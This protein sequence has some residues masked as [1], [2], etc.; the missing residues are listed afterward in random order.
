ACHGAAE[1]ERDVQK[2]SPAVLRNVV[3]RKPYAE[4]AADKIGPSSLSVTA[5]A[6]RLSFR[7]CPLQPFS[8][9][10][11]HFVFNFVI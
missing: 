4:T 10:Q 8:H 3:D 11:T 1:T 5:Q 9:S 2:K 6:G 7:L